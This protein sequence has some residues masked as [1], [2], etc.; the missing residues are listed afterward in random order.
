MALHFL[1]STNR[2]TFR[3]TILILG[4]HPS[5]PYLFHSQIHQ[6]H[7][8]W[9]DSGQAWEIDCE[10]EGMAW[11]IIADTVGLAEVCI[12][13]L[14]GD[15][16]EALAILTFHQF[17]FTLR[18]H[19]RAFAERAEFE[20]QKPILSE[21]TEIRRYRTS[22]TRDDL[23]SP[24]EAARILQIEWP[25]T[26][27]TVQ[28]AFKKRTLETHPDRRLGGTHEQMKMVLFARTALMDLL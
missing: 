20:A 16:Q 2:Y 1:R 3:Q 27:E 8:A 18:E 22:A 24:E 9:Q 13:C 7:Y 23:P 19:L 28:K 5:F 4:N 21:E 14:E 10:A 17:Q 25:A 26:R 15:C 11:W 6:H 12:H